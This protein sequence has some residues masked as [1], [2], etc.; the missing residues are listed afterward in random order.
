MYTIGSAILSISIFHLAEL[1]APQ[2]SSPPFCRAV[3]PQANRL[4]GKTDRKDAAQA[5]PDLKRR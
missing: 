3:F 1:S 4:A 2:S 5:K